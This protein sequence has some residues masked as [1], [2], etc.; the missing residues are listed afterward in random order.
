M[1]MSYARQKVIQ[2]AVIL[3]REIHQIMTLKK[4]RPAYLLFLLK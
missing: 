1:T 2:F 4:L 3:Y